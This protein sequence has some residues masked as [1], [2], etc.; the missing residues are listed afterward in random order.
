MEADI[1]V[2][3]MYLMLAVGIVVMLGFAL[4]LI[5]FFFQSQRKLLQK[6]MQTQELKL[7]H[8]QQLTY[9]TYK[10]Q[11]KERRRIAQDLHDEVGA[12]LSVLFLNLHQLKKAKIASG[13]AEIIGDMHKLVEGTIATTRRISHD[14][15]PPTLEKFGLIAALKE[16]CESIRKYQGL[17]LQFEINESDA[18]PLN[19]MTALQIFRVIQELINNTLKHAQADT[20]RL[21]LWTDPNGVRIEYSDNGKGFEHDAD[22][23]PNGL[24]MQNIENRLSMINAD[25]QIQTAPGKGMLVNISRQN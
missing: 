25:Y 12:K 19:D 17:K 16:L 4:T 8:Q 24:G 13:Q 9:A 18:K 21:K 5:L 14:L 6:Q 22:S 15:L 3:N 10:V 23:L 11:E 20:I 7:E 2:E 1:S